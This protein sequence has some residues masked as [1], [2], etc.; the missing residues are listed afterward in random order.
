[1]SAPTKFLFDVDFAGG[2]ERKQTIALAE[3]ARK[4]ADAEAAAHRRGYA[5]AQADAKLQT[6]RRMVAALERLAAGVAETSAALGAIEARLE[7]DA[8]EVAIAVA[9]KLAPALIARQPLEEII[10]LAG[11]CFRQLVSSPHI[12][13][14]VNDNLY[15]ATREK[16]DEIARAR[17]FEGRLVVL[18]EQDMAAGDCRIEWADGGINRSQASVEAAIGEAVVNYLGARR[19]SVEAHAKVQETR[20]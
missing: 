9:R 1:M 8:V 12:A 20:E 13:V 6:D 2:G 19:N 17:G 5:A 3:H 4:L 16:L 14:R 10:A 11:D 18:A 7:R 15:A